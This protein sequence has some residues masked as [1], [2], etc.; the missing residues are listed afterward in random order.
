M[1]ATTSS[2]ENLRRVF[3]EGFTARDI[4]EPLLSFDA[5]TSAAAAVQAM[6]RHDYDALGV[7]QD[8]YVAGYA[9]R[10]ELGEDACGQ[11]FRPFEESQLVSESAPLADVV[12][13]LSKSPRLFVWVLG[14]VG[15]IITLSDMQ[16]PPVRM[17]LFGMIT[18]IEMRLS[19]LIKQMCPGESWK[20]QVSEGRLQKAESLLEERRRR[21]QSLELLDCLQFS[22]KGQIVARNEQIRTL[23]RFPSRRQVEEEIKALESLRNNLAHSQDILSCDWETIVVLCQDLEGVIEGSEQV[24]HVLAGTP[25]DAGPGTADARP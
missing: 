24:R 2:T 19:R 5:S 13:R 11:Y 17:W 3:M 10:G 14:A 20:K 15:G 12:L 16:K 1:S 22:D 7:R 25:N 9:V 8:G 23:T 18:L 21:N 4:A 6:D